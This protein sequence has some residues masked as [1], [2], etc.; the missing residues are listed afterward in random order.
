LSNNNNEEEGH[1]VNDFASRMMK[2]K[3]NASGEP[4]DA[5]LNW[6]LALTSN[7][8]PLEEDN[9]SPVSSGNRNDKAA[10]AAKRRLDQANPVPR[11]S[12][13]FGSDVMPN[14]LAE[15]QTFL[16][17]RALQ[18]LLKKG[19]QLPSGRRLGQGQGQG[20]NTNRIEQ[21]AKGQYVQ[22]ELKGEDNVWTLLGEFSDVKHNEIPEPPS[23][24]NTIIWQ[25]DYDRAHYQELLFGRGEGAETMAEYFL[26]QSGGT[27]TVRGKAEEWA[28]NGGTLEYYGN[29]DCGDIVC[30]NVWDFV[31]DTAN[32]WYDKQIL[33]G[34]SNQDI[35]DY[36]AQYD[37]G[38]RYDYNGNGDFNEP[39]GYID[40]IQFVHAG[41]GQET[42][43]APEDI[44]SHRWYAFSNL[45][46]FDG[47][48]NHA[49]YGGCEIGE[50][51][52]WIGDYTINPE[53]G[54]LGVFSHEFGHDLGLID[55]YDTSGGSNSVE[56]WSLYSRGSYSGKGFDNVGSNPAPMSSWEKFQLGW[57]SYEVVQSGQQDTVMLGPVTENSKS[58]QAA[59]LVLPDKEVEEATS[60]QP[61]SGDYFY[62]SGQG[63]NL[64]NRMSI[65]VSI[66]AGGW[67]LVAQVIF[68]IEFLWDFAYLEVDGVPVDTSHS[69]NVNPYGTNKGFGITGY[70]GPTWN[71]LTADLTAYNSQS[72][73]IAFVYSTDEYVA[74][75]GFYLD[76]I[77]IINTS[78]GA[79]I[80]FD[81]VE[82]EGSPGWNFEGFY[83]RE[84]V[85]YAL[86]PN[87]YFA[88]F[89]TYRGS[90]KYTQTGPYSFYG[91]GI[92]VEHFPYQD[93]LLVW[94]WDTSF[95]S[96][97]MLYHCWYLG[98]C[99]GIILP[100]DAHPEPILNPDTGNVFHTS[101]QSFD[102]T[103][104]L[105][106][107]DE[108]C[109]TLFSTGTEM[110]VGGDPG[111][112]LF[113]DTQD[114]WFQDYSIRDWGYAGVEVPKTGTTIEV[115]NTNALKNRMQIMING[116]K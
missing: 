102:S 18:S 53:N 28:E 63:D 73:E 7:G 33:A 80:L 98:R 107:V 6:L 30:T 29:D 1:D 111:N 109:F 5:L 54:G 78:S 19:S 55:L 44:W 74:Y 64:E 87:F 62:H 90:D 13:A 103:F 51:D 116:K 27:Y 39:D 72:V 76:D 48:L 43:G 46:N 35:K 26:E 79:N 17:Q 70:S 12:L 45:I 69:T 94:Y 81:D 106:D 84:T 91:D 8:G 16:K 31:C 40:H 93:G 86:F 68:D 14:P 58:A 100:V 82:T 22:L 49:L 108:F 99:G 2:T 9:S 67:Q 25:E 95:S 77:A 113:D 92:T 66:P 112:P 85:G 88:E 71:V 23:A 97:Q 115:I 10:A 110:C 50:T 65:D 60:F 41:R 47:P 52:I 21:V 11:P 3:K 56:F 57:L 105:D 89:R 37:V 75:P 96:N 101:I 38:D 42:T 36:L 24:D 59:I 32:N 61:F 83:R 15:H 20:S 104:S 4:E 34:M 114:Y